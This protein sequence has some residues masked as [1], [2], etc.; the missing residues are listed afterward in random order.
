MSVSVKYLK[1]DVEPFYLV[2]YKRSGGA[3]Q[4]FILPRHENSSKPSS[5]S[6]F[7]TD[8]SVA[9]KLDTFLNDGK[10]TDQ[11]YA[12]LSKE[13]TRTVS[14][15]ITSPKFIDNGKF[16]LRKSNKTNSVLSE[17]E[18]LIYTV[19]TVTSMMNMTVFS[20]RDYITCNYLP[21]I[22]NNVKKFCVHGNS[23]FR[24]DTAFELIDGLWLTDT[25]YTNEGLLDSQGKHPEF[26][27]LSMSHFRK[28]RQCYRRF[29]DN[30]V[31]GF[32][33]W[34]SKN[35][36]VLFCESVILSARQELGIEDRF[37]INGLEFKHKLQ[38]KKA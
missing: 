14:D 12:K 1:K 21:Q 5:G 15:T 26:P 23:I 19:K 34:F 10:S 27:G 24:V 31:P 32:H 36:K 28:D 37:Y 20:S 29:W 25:I 22:I 6:Y 30:L 8:P 11:V 35:R 9:E 33:K 16:N 2:I 4:N 18:T 7:K 17:A 13:N 38:K 3:D